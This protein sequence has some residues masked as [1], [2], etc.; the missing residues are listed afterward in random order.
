MR[1]T[2]ES[3]RRI[4]QLR[5]QIEHHNYQY[6][7][8][9]NPEVPD[10]EY[11]RLMR[12]LESLEQ[13]HPEF[14]SSESPTQRVGAQPLD[15]FKQVIHTVPMLSL[16]NAFDEQEVAD[17]DKRIREKLEEDAIQ[18]FAEPKLDGLAISLRYEQGKLVTAATRGDGAQGEDVT[19]N[20]RTIQSVPLKLLGKNIPDLLEVRGE[21]FMPLDGFEKL[22]Q[23]QRDN[24]EKTFA[25]PRNAA[26]GSLRQLDSRITAARPLT[27]YCYGLG[28]C[29][30]TIA[31][32]H[33]QLMNKLKA[34]GLPVNPLGKP[35][36]G[37]NA[38]LV[39]YQ[40]L[41]AQ[42][43]QLS[44]EI[45]GVVYKVDD[46]KQQQE[47]GFVSRA[48][49]W[50]IAHKFPAQEEM[51]VVENI[52]VQVGRTGAITPVAR[53]KP[54]F[55]GGVTVTNATLHNQDEVERKDVRIG[56]TV[57]VRR[58]GDVIP[59]VVSVVLSHRPEKTSKFVLPKTCP[60]CDSEVI[61]IEGEAVAR[62]S[63]GLFCPAQ[64]KEAIKHFASRKAMDIDGLGDKLVEQLADGGY[65][66][67]MADLYA[68]E[69]DVLAGLERMGN[70]SAENL[71]KALT[72][73]KE[74]TF[75]RFLYALG[76]REVG[77]ATAAS[78]ASHFVS[79][80]AL[81][82]ANE[83]QLQAI[84][85]IGPVV[86]RHIVT[87]FHQPHNR[88]VLLK[89]AKAGIHWPEPKIVDASEQ[90]LKG[91]TFVLTGTLSEMTR[92]EA[93]AKLQALG[94]KVTGSV[95]KKTDFVVAGTEAGSK[96]DKANALGV[97]VLNEKDFIEL[98]N[99]T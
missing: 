23:R 93:K 21:V 44:Y 72:K 19:Q 11:D 32:S 89:L 55:V 79:L 37:T 91:K 40:N 1:S 78:L 60:E 48:P 39:Y 3:K 63:G 97:Q 12:E 81:A 20:V 92:D 25:N 47:M 70:K 54:V 94:A 80:D 33:S 51:T 52:D 58:A 64:R 74:T 9:D 29:S 43:S 65:I 41:L 22:N 2:A 67:D 4:E 87:F 35:C 10:A 59:E 15:S 90:R 61:R 73:S 16:A 50:A 36:R 27:I 66:K 46:F 82:A 53:L 56:D 34:F 42:R 62:C 49:R 75:A 7:V 6:Y 99:E 5:E 26:A 84:Q 8:L 45:D 57:I 96:L 18:Y 76:I 77:E 38:L 86:A 83:E 71:A 28:E 88:E 24:E 95:S 85:D 31:Q 13:A 68:L 14:V 17:F 98:L 69:V 30:E